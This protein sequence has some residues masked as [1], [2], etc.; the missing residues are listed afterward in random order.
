MV[1]Q[2]ATHQR[3][4]RE[5]LVQLANYLVGQTS[6]VYSAPLDVRLFEQE[7]ETPEQVTTVLLPDLMVVCDRAKIDER[8][9]HGAPDLII[10]ILSNIPYRPR[11]Q[12]RLV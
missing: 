5:L 11:D 8:G 10:E 1:L 2:T 6:E 4:S 12:A 9:I 7:G 3:I